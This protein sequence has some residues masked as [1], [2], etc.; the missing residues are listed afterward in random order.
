MVLRTEHDLADDIRRKVAQFCNVSPEAVIQSIDVPS[1]YE[2]PLKMQEQR[3]DEIV[4]NKTGVDYTN[5]PSDLTRWENFVNRFKNAT[6]KVKIGIVGKYVELQ[7]AYKSITEALIQSAAY[8]DR[9][10]ETICRFD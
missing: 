2:V 3:L 5:Y 9:K 4:L 8:N 6:E 10:V 1:I 7:D